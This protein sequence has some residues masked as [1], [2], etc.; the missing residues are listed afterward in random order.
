MRQLLSLWKKVIM[1]HLLSARE[2]YDDKDTE[3]LPTLVQSS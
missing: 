2:E 3:V 1:E